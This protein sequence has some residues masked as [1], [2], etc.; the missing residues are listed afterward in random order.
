MPVVALSAN[1]DGH[2]DARHHTNHL[3]APATAHHQR[4]SA[5]QAVGPLVTESGRNRAQSLAVGCQDGASIAALD[6]GRARIEDEMT[7]RDWVHA[8]LSGVLAYPLLVAI[9]FLLRLIGADIEPFEDAFA[10]I[11]PTIGVAVAER[12]RHNRAIDRNTRLARGEAA[13]M[14]GSFRGTG[15]PSPN[16]WHICRFDLTRD[17]LR[18]RPLYYPRTPS[19]FSLESV[20]VLEVGRHQGWRRRVM[21]GFTVV[22]C[23]DGLTT[24]ELSVSKED[25]PGL[26]SRVDG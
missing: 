11:G 22:A 8:V 12:W 16:R 25:V 13:T 21:T 10:G 4:Q 24:F 1:G 26:L 5:C 7:T 17:S 18:V 20:E 3:F 19:S 14:R 2:G 23:R 15:E 9:L 6:R